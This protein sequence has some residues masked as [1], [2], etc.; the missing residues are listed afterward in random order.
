[1]SCT[2]SIGVAPPVFKKRTPEF[3]DYL[4]LYT[5][6]SSHALTEMCLPRFYET[7]VFCMS[8]KMDLMDSLLECFVYVTTK[9]KGNNVHNALLI[10]MT[11]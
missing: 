3:N 2:R 5:N 11:D 8:K 9:R 6:T 4:T 10:K 7:H 1:V